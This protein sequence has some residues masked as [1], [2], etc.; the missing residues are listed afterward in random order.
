MAMKSDE[1]MPSRHAGLA[2]RVA[3]LR[4][5]VP[6]WRF[7]GFPPRPGPEASRLS[8][9]EIVS[10]FERELGRRRR[11]LTESEQR[12]SELARSIRRALYP[13]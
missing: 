11:A 10:L 3:R 9:E 6:S 12:Q 4:I 8:R 2:S 5:A 1:D 7:V 13:A